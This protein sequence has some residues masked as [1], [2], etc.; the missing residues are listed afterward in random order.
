MMNHYIYRRFF[1]REMIIIQP[2]HSSILK[3]KH[4]WHHFGTEQFGLKLS[5]ANI[6][7]KIMTNIKANK[8]M[9]IHMFS[10]TSSELLTLLSSSSYFPLEISSSFSSF[11]PTSRSTLSPLL[12]LGPLRASLGRLLL[13]SS[14]LT[15]LEEL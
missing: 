1:T 14:G 9:P 7:H 8:I 11:S 3:V 10:E 15:E 6:Y 5:E 13:P 2:Q 12:T 4:H